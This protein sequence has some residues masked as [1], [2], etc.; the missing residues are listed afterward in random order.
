MSVELQRAQII[1]HVRSPFNSQPS[2]TNYENNLLHWVV[3]YTYQC[4]IE[5]C[6]DIYI[7]LSNQCGWE[8]YVHWKLVWPTLISKYLHW[9]T[10]IWMKLVLSSQT[11]HP[12]ALSL[13]VC[14]RSAIGQ[15]LSTNC[16]RMSSLCCQALTEEEPQASIFSAIQL[17]F[18]L[19][20][21]LGCT[22]NFEF[23]R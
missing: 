8:I 9:L 13:F 3:Y 4:M 21:L 15:N 5:R 22:C 7:V 23:D 2:I 16:K 14:I 17:V 12:C 6:Y 19:S 11:L 18:S 1:P 20:L 10:S